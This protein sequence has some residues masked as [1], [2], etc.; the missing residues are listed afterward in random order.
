MRSAIGRSQRGV[1][2]FIA[3]I[4]L[5]AMSLAGLA[6][7]RSVDT[8]TLIASNLAF[9]QGTTFVA[10]LGVEAARAWLQGASTSDLE[11]NKVVASTSAYYA[12]WADDIDL[13]N[14][15]SRPDFDWTSSGPSIAVTASPYTPPTGYTVRYVIHR[16]CGSIGSAA[17]IT[18][19]I[20]TVGTA[21]GSSAGSK[22]AAVYGAYALAAPVSAI[23]RV[24]VQ[25]TGPR[26]SRSYVQTIVF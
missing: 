25:V 15:D 19:C 13:L 8:G 12:S 7:M 21:S 10:D 17:T 16:L 14:N 3:L 2:L 9:R 26:N 5:V 4:I 23:Y 6:L 24:T 11:D 18:D 22:G 20:K 1:V